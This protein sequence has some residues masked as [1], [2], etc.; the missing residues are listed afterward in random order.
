MDELTPVV[1]LR[2]AK[3]ILETKGWIQ[4]G[5]DGPSGSTCLD[6][7]L[8]YSTTWDRTR[9]EGHDTK[10]A[11]YRKTRRYVL[12]AIDSLGSGTATEDALTRGSITDWNDRHTRTKESVLEVLDKAIELA[13]AS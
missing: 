11:V 2:K 6:G 13:E 1:A 7:A 12:T 4:N 5:F 8:R 3:T 10:D 9:P